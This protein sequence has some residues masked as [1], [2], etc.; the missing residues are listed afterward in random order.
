M[1]I[2]AVAGLLF[3][4]KLFLDM[5]TEERLTSVQL[6]VPARAVA[7]ENW[8]T[9]PQRIMLVGDSRIRR[10]TSLPETPELAFAKSGVGGET[11]GQLERR[12]EADVLDYTPRPTELVIAIGVNDL[13]A[14]SLYR[15][16]G[17]E[18]QSYVV[19]TILER[20]E[21]LI[22]KAQNAGLKVRLATIVQPAEPDLLRKLIFWDDSLVTMTAEAN[23]QIVALA[24]RK[25]LGIVDFNA[26]LDGGDGLLPARFAADT[27]HFTA[28]AY[29]T[30]N[31]GLL[32]E[33]NPE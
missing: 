6:P 24:D 17:E 16:W 11:L 3:T 19:S 8:E 27:L 31:V 12:F 21:G 18:F 14:A 23:R 7:T 33:F 22:E 20:L 2:A 13:V 30:L 25:G 9:A 5:R 1:A 10:W 26:M 32:Q 29:E 28:A 4:F 15:D